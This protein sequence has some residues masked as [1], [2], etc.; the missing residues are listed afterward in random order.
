MQSLIL[1]K[2]PTYLLSDRNVQA[3]RDCRAR[4]L[5]R[6]FLQRGN[7]GFRFTIQIPAEW[8][9]ELEG[10]A[11]EPSSPATSA[12]KIKSRSRTFVNVPVTC[13]MNLKPIAFR[14]TVGSGRPE[15]F[16]F[17]RVTWR[18]MPYLEP[19]RRYLFRS[20]FRGFSTEGLKN[21]SDSTMLHKATG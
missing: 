5:H 21:R 19:V 11:R 16:Y 18:A 8:K 13:H 14:L 4:A 3:G 1:S 15:P 20:L 9:L 2:S 10:M 6:S 12:E 7:H 17:H